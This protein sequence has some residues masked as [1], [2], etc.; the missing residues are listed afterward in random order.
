MSKKKDQ[1][2]FNQYSI[3]T[4]DAWE[5]DDRTMTLKILDNEDDDGDEQQNRSNKN[6]INP[7]TGKKSIHRLFHENIF[8]MLVRKSTN[9]SSTNKRVDNHLN[10]KTSVSPRS[11]PR[12]NLVNTND[13]NQQKE[14]KF[15]Q[16]F[17]Q[18]TVDLSKRKS[19]KIFFS[20]S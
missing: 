2:K 19:K 17:D 3:N 15:K 18:S 16:I 12:S 9:S 5:I 7:S 4:D 11:K 8:F 20:I 14:N 13:V 10:S 6:I 1:E